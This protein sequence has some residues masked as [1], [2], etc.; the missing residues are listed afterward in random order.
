MTKVRDESVRGH[1]AQFEDIDEDSLQVS[2]PKT[3]A[4]GLKAVEV[5]FA[6]GM[7]QGG[8]SR[9]V[10]SMYRVNQSQGVDCPGLRLARAH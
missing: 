1:A 4:A 9:T 10:R 7:A 6:R 8:L 5:S 2:G 3:H